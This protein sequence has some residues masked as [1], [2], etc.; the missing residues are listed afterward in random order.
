MST[1]LFMYYLLLMLF[2]LLGGPYTAAYFNPV[3]AYVLT[4]DC[5]GK[6]LR[7]YSIVY[8]AG[9]LIGEWNTLE[10]LNIFIAEAILCMVHIYMV[11]CN[12]Y[13]ILDHLFI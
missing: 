9:A 3:L 5:P 11:Y 6:T 2:P 12:N 10:E 13:R 4:F 7:E 1:A 8:I